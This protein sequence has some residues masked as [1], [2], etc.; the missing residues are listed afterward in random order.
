MNPMTD[1][2]LRF[3]RRPGPGGRAANLAALGATAVVALLVTF[4]IAGS[5]GLAH[6]SDRIGWRSAAKADPATA[7]GAIDQADEVVDGHPMLRLDLA[8]LRANEL[9]PPPGLD[10]TP[11]PGEVFVSPEVAR[12]WAA[13]S[14][15]YGVDKP[16]GVISGKGLSSP[17]EFIVIRGVD[18]LRADDHPQ[19]VSSWNEDVWDSRMLG[20]LIAVAFGITP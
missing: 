4:L 2:G 12:H 6:R 7:I 10:Q 1:L 19:Y 14:K 8:T 5:L 11:K 20:L 17:E 13:L 16:T 3:V 15:Q 18:S 9:P